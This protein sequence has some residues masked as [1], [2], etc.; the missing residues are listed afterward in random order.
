MKIKVR[1]AV[2]VD[3][4]G[5]WCAYG[6]SGG[7]DEEMMNLACETLLDGEA[8]YWIEAAL[9]VPEIQTVQAVVERA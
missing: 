5:T 7:D 1:I 8:R 3:H 4:E 2:A 6:S 9:D